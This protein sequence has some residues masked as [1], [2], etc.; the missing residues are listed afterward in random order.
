MNG[1]K[2]GSHLALGLFYLFV[3]GCVQ[4]IF[5]ILYGANR[6]IIGL[7]SCSILDASLFVMHAVQSFWRLVLRSFSVVGKPE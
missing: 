4:G 3:V 5:G 7:S 2:V 1:V 6:E